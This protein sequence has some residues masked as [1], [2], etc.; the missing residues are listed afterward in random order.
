M[1]DRRQQ[2]A[3]TIWGKCVYLDYLVVHIPKTNAKSGWKKPTMMGT[4]ILDR[5]VVDHHCWYLG[6]KTKVDQQE[7][8]RVCHHYIKREVHRS[9]LYIFVLIRQFI[10]EY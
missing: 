10:W 7:S 9:P 8:I 3:N 2:I 6:Q 1:T 5:V 4:R